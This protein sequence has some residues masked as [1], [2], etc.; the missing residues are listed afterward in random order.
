MFCLFY[1][2]ITIAAWEAWD[3]RRCYIAFS[4]DGKGLKL[5]A[6]QHAAGAPLTAGPSPESAAPCASSFLG[7]H[8]AYGYEDTFSGWDA[9][10][11][12]SHSR[13]IDHSTR[14]PSN[15]ERD[16]DDSY[17]FEATGMRSP[18]KRPTS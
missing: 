2:E 12:S 14:I 13:Q 6:M 15:I 17:D 8:E 11:G 1:R 4:V 16:R 3:V 18:S 7:G 10:S 5:L 9:L